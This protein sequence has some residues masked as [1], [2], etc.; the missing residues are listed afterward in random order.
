MPEQYDII[1]VGGGSSGAVVAGRISEDPAVRVLLV[2][3]G[4]TD[5]SPLIWMP[6]GHAKLVADPKHSYF[7]AASRTGAAAN[8]PPEIILRGRGLGGSSSINGMVYHRGQP[9]DYDE[10][11]DLGLP[12]WSWQDVLPAFMAIED[13]P[14]AATEWRARGGPV[15]VRAAKTVPPLANAVIRAASDLG[16]PFKEESNLPEQMGIGPVSENIDRLGRRVS[17]AAAFLP[18]SVRRRPNLRILTNCRIDRILFKDKRAIGVSC[19]RGGKPQDYYAYKSV[20]LCTGTYETPRL[21]QLS[22]VGPADHLRSFGIEPVVDL[23]GVG[24]NY[25]DHFSYTA[26]WRLQKAHDSENRDY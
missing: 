24:Q 10:W 6:K 12:G 20:V 17:S 14:L 8:G 13:N 21:L 3:A 7:Y 26:C 2:E 23:P 22:G 4:T 25:R 1:V 11:A 18:P 5:R 15:P 16:L 9:E 19:S